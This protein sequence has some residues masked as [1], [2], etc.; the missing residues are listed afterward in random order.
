[1]SIKANIFFSFLYI[2]LNTDAGSIPFILLNAKDAPPM[3]INPITAKM[4]SNSNG[5]KLNIKP[6][7]ATPF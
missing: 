4:A 5:E 1:L 2:Y 6:E 7:E 3:D